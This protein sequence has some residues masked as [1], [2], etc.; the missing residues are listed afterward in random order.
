MTPAV[1]RSL[2]ILLVVIVVLTGL[3]LAMAMPSACHDC[4]AAVLGAAA[5]CLPL[6]LMGVAVALLVILAGRRLRADD[7]HPP[8]WLLA[9]RFERPPRWA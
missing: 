8:P 7:R 9:L 1:R 2:I 5:D 3:P 4:G 6:A